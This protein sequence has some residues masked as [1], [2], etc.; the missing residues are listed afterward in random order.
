MLNYIYI[1]IYIKSRLARFWAEEHAIAKSE[2]SKGFRF[3]GL[4][5]KMAKLL[6]LRFPFF[7]SG[8]SLSWLYLC[9]IPSGSKL[10]HSPSDL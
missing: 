4:V 9:E 10:W 5:L 8:P 3:G 1:Y 7:P 6:G 2:R